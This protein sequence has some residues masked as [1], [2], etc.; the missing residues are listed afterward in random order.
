MIGKIKEN[1]IQKYKEDKR[2]ERR[3]I[4][5]IRLILIDISHFI[6]FII[7]KKIVSF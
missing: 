1:S 2:F 7:E 5:Q 4:F 3:D 6:F